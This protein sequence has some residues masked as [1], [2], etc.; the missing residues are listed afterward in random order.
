MSTYLLIA[1]VL[2]VLCFVHDLYRTRS[3]SVGELFWLITL[4]IM[5]PVGIFFIVWAVIEMYGDKKLI[6]LKGKDK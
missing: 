4:C 3:F 2:F 5:W 6:N 1:C